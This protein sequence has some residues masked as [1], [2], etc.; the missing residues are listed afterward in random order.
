MNKRLVWLAPIALAVLL[1]GCSITLQ[2]SQLAPNSILGN[3]VA[4]TIEDLSGLF[5]DGHGTYH[6]N[7]DGMAFDANL[8][9]ARTWIYKREDHRSATLSLTFEPPG[10]TDLMVNCDLT[11]RDRDSGEY[12]CKYAQ[13]TS[14][15][16]VDFIVKGSSDGTF[17]IR[18]I[19]QI[20]A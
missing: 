2:V 15:M 20:G 11:F 9:Q 10:S 19:G 3:S 17:R 13:R 7:R 18:V 6:F 4:F 12:K 1:S 8:I 16:V 14:T 5:P